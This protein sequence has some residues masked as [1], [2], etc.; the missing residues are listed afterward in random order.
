MNAFQK[1][2]W[3]NSQIQKNVS[4]KTTLG[5]PLKLKGVK[6]L[7]QKK[8]HSGILNVLKAHW[9]V[10]SLTLQIN[11]E[12]PSSEGFN[13][14]IRKPE[15]LGLGGLVGLVG[16]VCLVC[17]VGLVGLVGWLVWLV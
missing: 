5:K 6:Q 1:Q 12:S 11:V 14:F 7:G 3:M 16:L 2:S 13:H 4:D 9:P 15:P 10:H 8:V 17:L